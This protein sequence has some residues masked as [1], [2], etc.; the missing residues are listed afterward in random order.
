[1]LAGLGEDESLE[2]FVGR[3]PGGALKYRRRYSIDR[4]NEIDGSSTAAFLK[5]EGHP[6][7]A[8]YLFLYPIRISGGWAFDREQRQVPREARPRFMMKRVREILDLPGERPVERPARGRRVTTGRRGRC[9][10]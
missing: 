5:R 1:M 7:V 9:G 8:L 6:E 10:R 3:L 4:F 2:P